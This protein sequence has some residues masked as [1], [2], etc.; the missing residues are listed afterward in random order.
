MGGRGDDALIRINLLGGF[1]IA[2]EG[3]Q[4]DLSRY[5]AGALLARLAINV[6]REIS[7]EELIEFL[8]PDEPLEV[9]RARLRQRLYALGRQFDAVSPGAARGLKATR[10]AVALDPALISTDL[11]EFE[12][13]AGLAAKCTGI[14]ERI[15]LL[16]RTVRIYSGPLLPG[17]YQDL[18]V[19][20]QFKVA[21]SY[22]HVLLGLRTAHEELGNLSEALRY[23]REM[24]A[25][26]SASD[27]VCCAIMRI[28]GRM[29]RS[30][31]IVRHFDEHLR[32]LGDSVG[33]APSDGV[34]QAK[35]RALELAKKTVPQL[36]EPARALSDKPKAPL[37]PGAEADSG[38]RRAGVR[39]MPRQSDS[40]AKRI[41]LLAGAM[42]GVPFCGAMFALRGIP[43]AAKTVHPT[44]GSFLAGSSRDGRPA[45]A[46]FAQKTGLHFSFHQDYGTGYGGPKLAGGVLQLLD[47]H[48]GEADAV[49][50]ELPPALRGF[51]TS[52]SFRV[53]NS[54][55]NPGILA[56]G[57]TFTVQRE[58]GDAL[59]G[60]GG[61]LGYAGIGQS[62]CLAIYF[63][64]ARPDQPLTKPTW[65]LF[66]GGHP[67]LETS[68]LPLDI[69]NGHT[70]RVKFATDG[71][72]TMVTMVD[73]LTGQS[74]RIQGPVG[75]C[76][77]QAC[78]GW[79][80]FTGGTGM[81]WA[82]LKIWD[83]K[84]SARS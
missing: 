16:E 66:S 71:R 65:G 73:D 63:H 76:V 62:F 27:D 25:L 23:A 39:G 21:D 2:S 48:I 56:D 20:E 42:I 57:F 50:K 19:A 79:V 78:P 58:R 33:S 40:R 18:F 74:A 3:V 30:E 37:C 1:S 46:I 15:Q 10:D 81:G 11:A 49:W 68:P 47:G 60:S 82:D 72:A 61:S 13:L 64:Q 9:S 77:T 45:P 55:N 83:W 44:S 29:G 51:D 17:F 52:F 70:Y 75:T 53:Q 59:G 84:F 24:A 31:A 26:D 80:G 4:R 22:W 7:R 6:G 14:T 67:P 69:G 43:A 5:L 34:R 12:A 35:E 28:L 38:S 32:D 8:W 36:D 54:P 41:L